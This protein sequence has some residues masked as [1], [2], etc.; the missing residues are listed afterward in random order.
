MKKGYEYAFQVDNR[1]VYVYGKKANL[2]K[3]KNCL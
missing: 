3:I 2:E 1:P